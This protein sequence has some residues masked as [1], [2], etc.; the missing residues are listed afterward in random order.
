M[1]RGEERVS[2]SSLCRRPGAR[3]WL[4]PTCS[5][6]A[7]RATFIAFGSYPVPNA[8]PFVYVAENG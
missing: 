2:R 4:G 1:H 5:F 6:P 3:R 8:N 7:R